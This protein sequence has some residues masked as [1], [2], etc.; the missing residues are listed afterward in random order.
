MSS[1]AAAAGAAAAAASAGGIALPTASARAAA[2]R[3]AAAASNRASEHLSARSP[4]F[5][6]TASRRIPTSYDRGVRQDGAPT[7]GTHADGNQMGGEEDD[8]SG[9]GAIARRSRAARFGSK[10]MGAVQVP[11]MMRWAVQE[12]VNVSNRQA[13]R[14]DFLRVKDDARPEAPA[15]A[16]TSH[17]GKSLPPARLALTHLAV[18]SPARY[19]VLYNVLSEVRK[20]LRHALPDLEQE[21]QDEEDGTEVTERK[22]RL[23]GWSPTKVIEWNCA[24][25]EGLWA[26]AEAFNDVDELEGDGF[27]STSHGEK[28][29]LRAYEGYDDRIPLLRAGM[30]IAAWAQSQDR[31]LSS[32]LRDQRSS[33]RAR[34][35]EENE[36][37]EADEDDEEGHQEQDS[38][39]A[40]FWDRA[41]LESVSTAF[42]SA[43]ARD[44]IQPDPSSPFQLHQAAE[45]EE[46]EAGPEQT[47]ALSSFALS[48]LAT[49]RDRQEHV[50]RMWKSG[51]E[52]IVVVDHATKRG[53]AS[54]ASARAFLLELGES[55]F[56]GARKANNSKE[57]EVDEDAE[58]L[59][60]GDHVFIANGAKATE[61]MEEEDE[62]VVEARGQS[63]GSH[64]VAPCPHDRPCPLLHPFKLLGDH[65]KKMNAP[66]SAASSVCSFSQRIQMPTYLRKT[67]HSN[68]GSEDIQYSYVV[69]RRG[70]RPVIESSAV[71]TKKEAEDMASSMSLSSL[72]LI[73]G[74]SDSAYDEDVISTSKSNSTKTLREGASRTK[75]GILD[76]LRQ[77]ETMEPIRALEEI[78]IESEVD[79]AEE[80]QQ[81]GGSE[82][83]LMDLLPQVLA[84]ELEKGNAALSEEEKTERIAA[85]MQA[86]L[87]AKEPASRKQDTKKAVESEAGPVATTSFLF[88][89]EASPDSEPVAIDPKAD[90][91][92][93]RLESYEW[94]RLIRP[95]LKKGGHVTFDACCSSG[96]I[97][98][99]TI[100]KSAGKQAYQD[101]RKSSWGDIFPHPP[102]NGK[103]SMRIP[104]ASDE[105]AEKLRYDE[106]DDY[107]PE[108]FDDMYELFATKAQLKQRALSGIDAE[109]GDVDHAAATGPRKQKRIL[110]PSQAIGADM[111]APTATQ[112][113]RAVKARET[114]EMRRP[115]KTKQRQSLADS[116]L[117]QAGGAEPSSPFVTGS[118][119]R[120]FSTY[121]GLG[122]M[123][124]RRLF[125]TSMR[126]QAWKTTKGPSEEDEQPRDRHR[127]QYNYNVFAAQPAKELTQFPLVTAKDLAQESSR[128]KEVRMLARDFI[129]DS[130]YN[131]HYGYFSRQAVLLPD[132][133]KLLVDGSA[134]EGFAFDGFK[135]ERQFMR[136]VQERY[137]HFEARFDNQTDQTEDAAA[138][139]EATKIPAKKRASSKKP[140]MSSAEG[141]DAAKAIGKVWK[142]QQEKNNIQ[143]R[144]ILAMAARQVWHTPTELFKP[145]Y[146]RAIAR[147]IVAEYKLHHY[148]YDDL[149]IYELGAGSGALAN[150]VLGYLAAEEPEV[151]SRTRYRI[152]E[153]SSRL[154]EQQRQK[155]SRHFDAGRVQITNRSFLDWDTPVG[156]PAFVIALEVLDNLAHDVIRYSTSTLEPY[157]AVV[158]IDETNEMHELWQPVTDPL[159]ARYLDLLEEV[160]PGQGPPSASHLRYLPGPLRKLMTEYM[161]LYP[162]LT[163]PHFIPTGQ[164]RF[165]E[166]LRDYFPRHRLIVSDFD[167]L[168]D[169]V[170]GIDAPVVQ[171]RYRGTMVPVSTY[172]VLQGF[173]DIFFP[174]DFELMQDVYGLVMDGSGAAGAR[175]GAG[176]WT[177]QAAAATTRSQ[178]SFG[179]EGT[180]LT[181]SDREDS[182][183]SPLS[184]SFFFSAGTHEAFSQRRLR[185]PRLCTHAE[186]LERYAEVER[187]MLR[188]GTNPMVSWYANASFFL[189]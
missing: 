158:S 8:W 62:E 188:D 11:K 179:R 111:V 69:V 6:R 112:D 36:D 61:L 165:L 157:Q 116:S 75:G 68:R 60:I 139:S 35:N 70:R 177:A 13:L 108:Q 12:M 151:Y 50:R 122:A 83:E 135:N 99:F 161:P 9:S 95:P 156:E 29:P 103:T 89:D 67:K 172:C 132:H 88:D 140:A 90:E 76:Q 148:P 87:A 25:A 55:T 137:M 74:P 73:D 34:E 43:A 91:A 97:E 63:V 176:R 41:S 98:R 3:S 109:L 164:L 160:R 15:G 119:P 86:V 53:F 184:D 94:P 150:D 138:D 28:G 26:A 186:F 64:V 79:G 31:K 126:G 118:A 93:M 19:A 4:P 48:E 136:N 5:H 51:A 24:A 117:A 2:L 163:P 10:R 143:E 141:L 105:L 149:V 155:L 14:Q 113:R 101:A 110:R 65:T 124:G 180:T 96:A 175:R 52:V 171:T 37:E 147:Y 173:F 106:K 46:V 77:G 16:L 181:D 18:S 85:A 30:E 1:S 174:T 142:A 153:I 44:P 57:I 146:A 144:D 23:E 80:G 54:I 45:G 72:S 66:L 38:Q 133:E 120:M 17:V 81:L 27:S 47:L 22:W 183:P 114:K 121:V 145:H 49:D 167:H 125:S 129:D 168:P 166:V 104:A 130:L 123:G 42:R 152:V 115:K 182:P 170:K 59:V 159:V 21:L 178:L 32:E 20:R 71:D 102:K 82:E 189:S 40:A 33:G 134:T 128:P 84:A 92:A 162:N 100:P 169:A 107:V 131:P 127:S 185:R 187:T 58:R 39:P 78:S 56:P 7:D 154:A